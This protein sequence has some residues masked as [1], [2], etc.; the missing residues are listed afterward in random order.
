MVSVSVPLATSRSQQLF[1]LFE[2]IDGGEGKL[3][4]GFVSYSLIYIKLDNPPTVS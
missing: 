4:Y 3:R 1:R 2:C